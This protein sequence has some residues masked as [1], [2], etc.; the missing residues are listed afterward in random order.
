MKT[1]KDI[2]MMY[3]TTIRN[4]GLYTSISLAALAYS[5][6]YRGKGFLRNIA[7]IIIS[8]CIISIAISINYYLYKDIQHFSEKIDITVIDKWT[9]LLPFIA[10]IQIVIILMNLFTLFSEINK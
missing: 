3:H 2:I 1:E 4:I 10:I 7:G 8:I 9:T 5:R 6:A